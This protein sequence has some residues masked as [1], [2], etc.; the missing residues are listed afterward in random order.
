VTGALRAYL[1]RRPCPTLITAAEYARTVARRA[2]TELVATA[3]EPLRPNNSVMVR[4]Y[5]RE[6]AKYGYGESMEA[7]ERHFVESSRLA[8]EVVCQ[9]DPRARRATTACALILAAWLHGGCGPPERAYLAEPDDLV[10]ADK[11]ARV[12]SL[13]RRI[14]TLSPPEPVEAASTALATWMA[15]IAVLRATLDTV[16]S[17]DA[18]AVTDICAHLVCNRLGIDL[19]TERFLRRVAWRALSSL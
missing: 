1:D 12:A 18:S 7:V 14:R 3:P 5:R 8:L 17:P 10:T 13:A 11:V 2:T 4:A 6:H 9:G 16:P 19:G 15:S